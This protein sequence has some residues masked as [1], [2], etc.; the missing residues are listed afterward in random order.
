MRQLPGRRIADQHAE[1]KQKLDKTRKH[2]RGN[3]ADNKEKKQRLYTTRSHKGGRPET[4][5]EGRGRGGYRSTGAGRE[6]R[7]ETIQG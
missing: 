1:E 6:C 3:I 4:I 2:K 7:P 5:Q